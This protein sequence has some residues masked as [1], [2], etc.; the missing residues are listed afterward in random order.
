MRGV[1]VGLKSFM[2]RGRWT[3]IFQEISK[4]NPR[5]VQPCQI[6]YFNCM[7]PNDFANTV[8]LHCRK[9]WRGLRQISRWN[10]IFLLLLLCRHPRTLRSITI[11]I[12]VQYVISEFQ[13][14]YLPNLQLH[15]VVMLLF[16]QAFT[17]LY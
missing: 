12:C 1:D 2:V 13:N 3:A 17:T 4:R 10:E 15:C 5:Y 7:L 6:E 16:S 14:I 9:L 8:M 11:L